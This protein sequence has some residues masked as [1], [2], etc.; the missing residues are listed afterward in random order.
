MTLISLRDELNRANLVQGR[1][2]SSIISDIHNLMRE[3]ER[4]HQTALAS[5]T[6]LRT[7]MK[8][9]CSVLATSF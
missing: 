5:T 7:D 2:I 4:F 3:A 6:S 8:M 9:L 1:T